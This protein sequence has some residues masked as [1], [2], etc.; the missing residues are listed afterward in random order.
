MVS[1]QSGA[2]SYIDEYQVPT[3]NS[4]PLAIAVDTHGNVWFTE[5]NASKLAKFDPLTKSFREYKVPWVGDMWGIIIN[6]P[7]AIWF[8]QYSGKGNVNPGGAIVGGGEGRI[9]R[10]IITTENFTS[11]PIPTNGSF[12]IRLTSDQRGRIWFTEL[13]GNKLGV[14]D[15]GA[16]SLQ[17]Y[18]I[19]TNSS[20]PTD[21]T[22]DSHGDLWFSE[23][24]AQQLGK[25]NP[26]TQT[27]TEYHLGG[28]TASQIVSSPVGVAVDQEGNVWVADHGGNWIVEL[29]PQTHATVKYPT[30]FP[31]ADVYP[32]S[33]VNDLLIDPQGHIW[34]AEHGGNSIGYFEPRTHSMVEFPIPTGPLS[35]TLWLTLAPNG[36]V[37]F[38]EWSGNKIGVVHANSLI[39]L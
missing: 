20:G 12:P 26:Q 37:W 22:F 35:T 21:L 24:F 23:S 2:P 6:P 34:F 17:E 29:N 13:L 27:I 10:F 3:A 25:F 5:S 1:A 32:I 33:L 36:D 8:T 19:P 38:A 11:I 28:E 16:N 4:A 15:P 31:P 30:H 14:Y 7:D 18:P 9:V 39:P